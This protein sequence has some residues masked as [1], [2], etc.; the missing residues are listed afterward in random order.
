LYEKAGY[1]IWRREPVSERLTLVF[2]EKHRG[3]GGR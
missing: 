3:G 2:M 1:R